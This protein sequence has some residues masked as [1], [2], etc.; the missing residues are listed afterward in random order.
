M[1]ILEKLQ[2]TRTLILETTLLSGFL[3]NGLVIKYASNNTMLTNNIT[4][5]LVGANFEY[6]SGN[7]VYHNNF[8][9]NTIQ[10][11]D[12][13]T[14]SENTWDNGSEG[15]FWSYYNGTDGNG[16]G[17]GDVPYLLDGVNV[18]NFPLIFPYDVENDT[19]MVPPPEPFPTTLAVASI[20][21]IAVIGIGILV[22]FKKYK[23]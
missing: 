13:N 5:N 6:S 14:I 20:G 11:L 15:N 22:Y 16:D 2:F 17:I 19:I 12:N 18:D 23:K 7:L 3:Q 1:S 9:N 21:I 4:D 8:I 10:I